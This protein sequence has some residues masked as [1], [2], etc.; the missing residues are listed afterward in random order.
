[1]EFIENNID[2]IRK[3]YL[4]E[5]DVTNKFDKMEQVYELITSIEHPVTNRYS[6]SRSSDHMFFYII[7]IFS[8]LHLSLFILIL[9][10]ASCTNLKCYF[11]SFY[12]KQ[13]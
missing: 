7:A 8:L 2:V 12:P 1:M 11:A 5:N 9:T 10:G 3:I 6:D 4:C 13:N